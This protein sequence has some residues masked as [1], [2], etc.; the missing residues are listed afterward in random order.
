LSRSNSF[1]DDEGAKAP[2]QWNLHSP[3]S[4][5]TPTSILY[6]D[7]VFDPV[8]ITKQQK[9]VPSL[10][11][12]VFD[13]TSD[14][15][16]NSL[17]DNKL[18][19]DISDIR[20]SISRS[21][22][23][24]RFA[25]IL[26]S[27]KT[28]LEAPDI[29]ERLANIRRGTGLDP[30]LGLFFLPPNSSRV[31]VTSF[32]TSF[33]TT[34]QPTCVEYYR[35][36]TK[37]S[38]RK[39]NRGSVP[40]PTIA[41]TTSSQSLS[42]HGWSIRYDVKQGI[43]A[44]FRQEM[45]AACRH[46]TSALESLMGS[47]G[48]FETTASWSPRWNEGRILADMMAF[49]IIRCLLWSQM[50]TTAAQSWINYRDRMRELVDRRGKG[51]ANYGWEAWESRWAKVMAQLI[52]RADVRALSIVDSLDLT[53]STTV[54][55]T[56]NTT[57][58]A[59]EKNVL[60]GDTI[61]PWHYLHHPGY[62]LRLSARN[63]KRR[64][65]YALD[66]PDEDRV[67]PGEAPASAVSQRSNN[68][69]MYL[70]P[71]PHEE[72]PLPPIQGFDHT[73]DVLDRLTLASRA[74]QEREQTRFSERI[75]LEIG[76]EL[77]RKG[78]FEDGVKLLKPL[79]Q[80][81]SWR[82]ERWWMPL[83][84]LIRT[85]SECAK[86]AK[87]VGVLAGTI[88]ELHSPYL[89]LFRDMK[90]DLMN[91]AQALRSEAHDEKP[92]VQLSAESIM[93]FL[94]ASL[95]FSSEQGH[96]GE[97]ARAQLRVFSTA[98]PNTAPITF[99]K[100]TTHFKPDRFSFEL[101]HDPEA[102]VPAK[103]TAITFVDL[104]KDKAITSTSTNGTIIFTAH[105]NL[106]F[107]PSQRTV[108]LL[109]F[110]V[111]D[112]GELAIESIDF[113]IDT[114]DYQLIYTVSPLHFAKPTVWF[115][116]NSG[117]G[118]HEKRIGRETPW[119]I[120]ILPK[121]PKLEMYI[122]D[123]ARAMY[124][125][126]TIHLD[127]EIT[128]AEEEAVV[129]TIDVRLLSK[130]KI[131]PE[132]SWLAH[133]ADST[134]TIHETDGS[135]PSRSHSLPELESGASCT[136]TATFTAPSNATDLV[137]EAKVHYFLPSDPEVPLSKIYTANLKVDSA[138]EANYEFTPRIHPDIWPSFF[139][140]DKPIP[141]LLQR[142]SLTTNLASF[143]AEPLI[144]K[145]VVL[146][147]TKTPKGLKHDVESN[148]EQEYEIATRTMHAHI[149]SINTTRPAV[150]EHRQMT[151]HARIKVTWAR[152]GESAHD[153]TSTLPVSPLILPPLEPRIVATA[154]HATFL[155]P[156]PATSPTSPTSSTGAN[157]TTPFTSLTLTLENPSQHPLTFD[158]TAPSAESLAFSGPK[159]QGVTLLPYSRIDVGYRMLPLIRGGNWVT[160]GIK[161]SDRYFARD[162][163]VLAGEGVRMADEGNALKWFVE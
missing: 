29:E 75:Q 158:I 33:L 66:I 142:W 123:V 79:W 46:Y 137:L 83:F 36:L 23:R 45:D 153:V 40:P 22:Y 141:G 65:K 27:D 145:N 69:D 17:N 72:Y 126:E 152:K 55:K 43:F 157:E 92:S 135:D 151:L 57:F 68:Y 82:R 32:V 4:P 70:A 154:K 146:E 28:I 53:V 156:S 91:C 62:W 120:D 7:G 163:P 128:N 88:F 101:I 15:N 52:Q 44:E 39:R 103:G 78:S 87:D 42:A 114:S 9:Q 74:F 77:L 58:L 104:T 124:T 113:Q 34:L 95:V 20:L 59:P 93:S 99:S 1:K 31:E 112:P 25:V 67:P 108:Y 149:F 8:W 98:H 131:T 160:F 116:S 41:P 11:V 73:G 24:T 2:S 63:A 102:P 89:R 49:R 26:L 94:N 109:S 85:L 133:S 19:T 119:T 14:I 6:P 3:L 118:A 162:V 106:T 150:K 12:A 140:I 47:E 161:V 121:P 35:D 60:P 125:D 155:I 136:R 134:T 81:C 110:D 56:G 117:N 100:V 18:K 107:Q 159:Q 16:T 51:S 80:S 90:L 139:S 37:H 21:H 127:F 5:L 130:D 115:L 111:K 97:I 61:P 122:K 144:V 96:V 148:E 138:F 48:I 76:R 143:A 129:A 50:G 71:E 84:E 54:A 147:I 13:F 30:K 105:A 64:R 86:G 132:V 10:F 38:R